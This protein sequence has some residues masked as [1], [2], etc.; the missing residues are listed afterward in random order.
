MRGAGEE[1]AGVMPG[2]GVGS[3]GTTGDCAW[4]ANPNT[5][6][7]QTGVGVWAGGASGELFLSESDQVLQL[8]PHIPLHIDART[9][10]IFIG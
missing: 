9:D 1:G 7:S 10:L 2:N 3:G 5:K 4:R 8:H 6:P